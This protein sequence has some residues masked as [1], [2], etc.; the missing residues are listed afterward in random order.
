MANQVS[1]FEF[2]HKTSTNALVKAWLDGLTINSVIGTWTVPQSS[3]R[4]ILVI[5]YKDS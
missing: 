4:S 1:Q 3:M 2:E 5:A